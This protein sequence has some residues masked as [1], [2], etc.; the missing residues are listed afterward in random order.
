M[1]TIK[2]FVIAFVAISITSYAQK[3]SVPDNVNK[4]FKQKFPNAQKVK[5]NKENEIEWEAEFKMNG[6]EYSANFSVDGK[7][8]ETEH[9]IEK[10]GIPAPVQQTLDTEFNGYDI[11]EA[12]ISETAENPV[13][14]F[15][16]EKDK[17]EMEV[18]I[19]SDGTVKKKEVKTEEDEED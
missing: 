19:S 5:W 14:E 10:S 3:Q 2:L 4:T 12:E 16:L 1:K 6:K 7:W 9:E 13:Y 18:A 11:E 8:M 17:Q 15:K